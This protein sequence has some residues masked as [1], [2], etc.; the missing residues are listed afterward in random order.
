MKVA[1]VQMDIAF[2]EPEKNFAKAEEMIAE[3]AQAGADCVVLPEMWNT[4]YALKRLENL[5]DNEGRKTKELLVR[6][7]KKHHVHIV[8]GSVSVKKQ[9]EYFNTMYVADRT[10]KLVAEYDKAHLFKLMNE[11]LYLEA[12][13]RKN[14][15][16]LDDYVCGGVICYDIRFPEWIRKHVVD[17]AKVMFVTAE[18]PKPRIDHWEILLKARAIENQCYIIAVNRVGKDPDNEFSGQSMVIAPW[19]NI[20]L[21]SSSEEG[22]QYANIDLDDVSDVRSRI[23]VFDDRRVELY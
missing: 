16:Q 10:G 17:G 1:C 3:A 13:E 8:G 5:A 19:G 11:H 20:L 4:G 15:F 18:W 2:A 23:P 21:S 14:I 12:G 22:I 6:L 7:A 9:G